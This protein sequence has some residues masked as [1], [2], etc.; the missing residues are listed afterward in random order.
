MKWRDNVQIY[1]KAIKVKQCQI[2]GVITKEK[3]LYL[4]LMYDLSVRY[5]DF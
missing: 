2:I 3:N 5:A 4:L 1:L